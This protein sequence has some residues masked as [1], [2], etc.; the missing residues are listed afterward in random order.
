M[1]H[2]VAL[3]SLIDEFPGAFTVP[4]LKP[5]GP[6]SQAS[7][8]PAQKQESLIALIEEFPDAFLSGDDRAAS[9][10]ASTELDSQEDTSPVSNPSHPIL[11]V[12][13]QTQGESRLGAIAP[14]G[15]EL[16][17]HKQVSTFA[18][19]QI[20]VYLR[21]GDQ[22]LASLWITVGKSGTEVQSLCEAIARLVNLL[23]G[24]KVPLTDIIK[25]IRGIR[26]GDSEGLGPHRF[27]G[28]VDLIGKII[29]D[30]PEAIPSVS[31]QSQ[32]LPSPTPESFTPTQTFTPEASIQPASTVSSID[33]NVLEAVSSQPQVALISNEWITLANHDLAFASICPDCGA[34][35]QQVNGC[36]GGACVVCGYS[37]CS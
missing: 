4:D 32:I 9:Q 13:S 3:L 26:G 30:A 21:Y 24:R 34:Q 23:R 37:S 33:E 10:E 16:G 35:L 31:V 11:Q 18:W 28:L 29:Q 6:S 27:L 2:T 8:D 22:G 14:V 17:L 1:A 25:E 19:G 7:E 12:E 15:Y 36:S 20:D 5:L